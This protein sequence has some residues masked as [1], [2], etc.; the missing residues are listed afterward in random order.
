MSFGD[1]DASEKVEYLRD[2]I[3]LIPYNEVVEQSNQ[4]SEETV[5]ELL[6]RSKELVKEQMESGFDQWGYLID[7][8]E[9]TEEELLSL[10]Y[11]DLLYYSVA[12]GDSNIKTYPVDFEFE[13]SERA[14]RFRQGG[15]S[16]VRRLLRKIDHRE[17]NLALSRVGVDIWGKMESSS[18]MRFT[19]VEDAD[20]VFVQYWF[21][22]G[23]EKKYHERNGE[24][25]DFPTIRRV[26]CRFHL[27]DEFLEMSGRN[28]RKTRQKSCTKRC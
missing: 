21:R 25:I 13:D 23:T 15:E 12:M 22:T 8:S 4:N 26:N 6:S 27:D 24:F 10:P 18:T 17:M 20:H 28:D 14:S 9:Y 11:R 5:A 19:K 7:N 3:P 1:M 2:C 16:E